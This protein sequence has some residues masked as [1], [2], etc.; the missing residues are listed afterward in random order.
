M[1]LDLLTPI[2]LGLLGFIEPCSLGA[3]AVFLSYVAPLS[4][5]RRV[6][7]V[8][9]IPA[10]DPRVLCDHSSGQLSQGSDHRFPPFEVTFALGYDRRS[11]CQQTLLV[12]EA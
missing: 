1:A 5:W 7:E 2:G 9:A 3:N 10:Y 8:P 12:M 6:A 4:G 11:C